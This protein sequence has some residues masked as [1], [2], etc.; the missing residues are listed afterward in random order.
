MALVDAIVAGAAALTA[1]RR[2]LHAH[3]EL[4]WEE[5]RTSDIVAVRLTEWGPIRPRSRVR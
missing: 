5:F 1:V 2:D 4:G 3:P